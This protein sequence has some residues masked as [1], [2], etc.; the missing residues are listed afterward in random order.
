MR[1]THRKSSRK[2]LARAEVHHRKLVHVRETTP[3]DGEKAV[4]WFLLTS[5]DV[6]SFETAI[7]V[8]G[9]YLQHWRVEDFF[10]VLKSGCRVEHL[11]FHTADRLQRT[12]TIN[13]VI[14]WRL[15]RARSARLRR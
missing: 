11:A 8:T 14:A 13:A 1:A 2:R 10:R 12:I 7:E 4:E 5:I 6:D 3:P 9:Y 15:T